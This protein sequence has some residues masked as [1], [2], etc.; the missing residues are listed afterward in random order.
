VFREIIYNG[1]RVSKGVTG[2]VRQYSRLSSVMAATEL[3]IET[4]GGKSSQ[5]QLGFNI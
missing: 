2:R 5:L 3:S 4:D 1:F